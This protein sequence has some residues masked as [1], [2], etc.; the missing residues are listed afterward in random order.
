ML[1]NEPEDLVALDADHPGF[2]DLEYRRR[3]TAITRVARAY[4]GGAVP[5]V[6][7][8]S[9]EQAVWREV[10]QVLAPLH[11]QLGC[12]EYL[13]AASELGL[14]RQH[15]PQLA[16]L[17]PRLQRAT[18][19]SML[20]VGGLVSGKKFLSCLAE[21]VFLSTQYIRHHSA[22]LYTPEPDIV[23]ELVGH[24]ALLT[25][26]EIATINRRIGQAALGADATGLLD[27]ERLY[28]NALEF[29]VLIED[30]E[31]KAVGAG[32]LSS[33]GEIR[34]FRAA[35]LL[36]WDIDRMAAT[37]YDPT[38]YQPHYFV[39]PSFAEMVS[40]IAAWVEQRFPSV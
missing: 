27:L 34:R 17:N 24:A 30:G 29:G 2:R 18:G 11:H 22:P 39:A 15:I 40:S 25:Q 33:A 6:D 16:E 36:P 3:R 7:Y 37:D 4:E 19:F 8:S 35:E 31:L 12:R 1:A 13:A 26:P 9:E 14:D 20:P 21:G 5:M 10:W 23:H 38:D 32:V 28:W